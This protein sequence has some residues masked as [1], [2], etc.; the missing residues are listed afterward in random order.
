MPLQLA[1]SP[2]LE[3][4]VLVS[5]LTLRQILEIFFVYT[6]CFSYY[7]SFFLNSLN[8]KVAPFVLLSKHDQKGI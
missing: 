2:Y 5:I 4:S 6:V 7:F 1:V 3:N 8:Q